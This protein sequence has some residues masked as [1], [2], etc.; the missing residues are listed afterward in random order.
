MRLSV[1]ERHLQ[2]TF[3]SGR[4]RPQRQAVCERRRV[5]WE[6]E[7]GRWRVI[8]CTL[9]RRFSG[10]LHPPGDPRCCGSVLRS[11]G[12]ANR[13]SFAYEGV[14][15]SRDEFDAGVDSLRGV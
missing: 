7:V 12:G 10:R 9:S 11:G 8:A 4:A 13:G 3:F 2:I 15:F 1:R 14:G 6:L 5:G